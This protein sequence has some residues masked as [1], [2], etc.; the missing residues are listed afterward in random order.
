VYSFNLEI[1]AAAQPTLTCEAAE[2]T[3]LADVKVVCLIA[4]VEHHLTLGKALGLQQAGQLPQ[5]TVR[6]REHDGN[7]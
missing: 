2:C 7:L 4:L 3:P 6:Q 1:T 5:L